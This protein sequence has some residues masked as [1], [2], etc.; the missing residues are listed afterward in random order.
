MAQQSWS[1]VGH[2]F[3]ITSFLT[4]FEEFQEQI[5]H[6]GIEYGFKYQLEE[7][8]S[9]GRPHVQALLYRKRKSQ[10]NSYQR[11]KTTK[12]WLTKT[13]PCLKSPETTEIQTLIHAQ[14]VY[15]YSGKEYTAVS[16]SIECGVPIP[17]IIKSLG[18]PDEEKDYKDFKRYI[19]VLSGPPGTGKSYTAQELASVVGD[20]YTGTSGAGRITPWVLSDY[21]GQ[22]AVVI[23][24]FNRKSYPDSQCKLLLDRKPQRIACGGGGKSVLFIA[25]HIFL[26]MNHETKEE[27]LMDLQQDQWFWTRIK[28]YTFM[29]EKVPQKFLE[30]PEEIIIEPS[31]KKQKI[32]K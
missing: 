6:I 9:T 28:G 10:G 8:P 27:M 29:S 18:A 23:D 11:W 3:N 32:A 5:K 15:N 25:T 12:D 21:K 22:L 4:S 20:V 1:S 14:R 2:Y 19:H 24:E 30:E 26:T 13:F 17:E 31:W 7:C 16:E